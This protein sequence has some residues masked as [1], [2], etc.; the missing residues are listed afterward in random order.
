MYALVY[1]VAPSSLLEFRIDFNHWAALSLFQF[2]LQVV[3]NKNRSST[4]F[5]KVSVVTSLNL[6]FL[7]YCVVKY[8]LLVLSTNFFVDWFLHGWCTHRSEGQS[9]F[10]KSEGEKDKA[11][12]LWNWSK[13]GRIDVQYLGVKAKVGLRDQGRGPHRSDGWA[14]WGTWAT[15]HGVCPVSLPLALRSLSNRAL[16]TVCR[17]TIFFIQV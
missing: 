1:L 9:R 6:S 5:S 14:H 8:S 2:C 17:P 10:R 16:A 11:R 13:G 7:C 12:D 4:Y 15:E 3:S